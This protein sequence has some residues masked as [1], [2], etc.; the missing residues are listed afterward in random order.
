MRHDPPVPEVAR[1]SDVAF[2]LELESVIEQRQTSSAA[3]SYTRR[4][5]DGGARAIGDKLEEEAGELARAIGGEEPQRVASEAADLLYHLLVGL[6]L[7]GVELR[8]VM[9]VLSDRARAGS[10]ESA[11]TRGHA[12][13]N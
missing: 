12:S 9:Q 8:A 5:L 3:E 13:G 11:A 6:R 1:Q 2:L 10:R 7:R 4:L